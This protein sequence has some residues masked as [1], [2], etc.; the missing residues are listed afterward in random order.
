MQV[1]GAG[2][3][4]TGTMSTRAALELLGYPCYHMTETARAP[5]HLDAWNAFLSGNSAMNWANLLVDYEATVDTP[6]CLYYQDLVQA[7]PSAK[8]LLTLREPEAWYESLVVLSTTLEE[9]RPF[10]DQSKR[11]KQFLT[12]TDHVGSKLTNGD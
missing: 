3:S 9:F 10:V 6:C 2:M 4:R 8:V 12:L 11:L 7:F 5:G 1:I